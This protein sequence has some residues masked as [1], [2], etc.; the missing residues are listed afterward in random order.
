MY[1]EPKNNL[2][3]QTNETIKV[4]NKVTYNTYTYF[5]NIIKVILKY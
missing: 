5:I 4:N 3:I 1:R 2:P